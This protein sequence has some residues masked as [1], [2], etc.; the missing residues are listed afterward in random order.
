LWERRGRRRRGFKANAGEGKANTGG[1]GKQLRSR[2]TETTF[3]SRGQ[4]LIG[5]HSIQNIFYYRKHIQYNT[6]ENTSVS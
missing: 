1:G 3:Y 6:I 4:T 2:A 5:A